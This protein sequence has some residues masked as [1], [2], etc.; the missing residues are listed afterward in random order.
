MCDDGEYTTCPLSIV[1]ARTNRLLMKT[2]ALP[3]GTPCVTRPTCRATPLSSAARVRLCRLRKR[4]LSRKNHEQRAGNYTFEWGGTLAPSSSY[5]WNAQAINGSYADPDMRMVVFASNASERIRLDDRRQQATALMHQSCVDVETMSTVPDANE[6]GVCLRLAFPD[7]AI[8]FSA[9][10]RTSMAY[11]TIF[12]CHFPSEFERDTYS[13]VA[14]DGTPNI[15]VAELSADDHE[16]GSYS[17]DVHTHEPSDGHD[18]GT[19]AHDHGGNETSNHDHGDDIPDGHDHG[20]DAPWPRPQ[21]RYSD[22]HDHGDDIP[23]GHDHGDD[24]P[25]GTT[26]ATIH[27]TTAVTNTTMGATATTMRI[28]LNIFHSVVRAHRV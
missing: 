12:T 24:V 4:R 22:E 28:L 21:R 5:Q 2:T 15:P 7:P 11:M 20:D 1:I 16:H 3:A 8:D 6:T 23:D 13:F 10:F 17:Y 18:H 19:D 9:T 14:N 25:D 26:T 27:T